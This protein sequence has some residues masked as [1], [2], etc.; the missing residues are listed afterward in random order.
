VNRRP[1]GP[2]TVVS[3][4]STNVVLIASGIGTWLAVSG[5]LSVA[6]N[7]V[8]MAAG[9]GTVPDSWG[10]M[11]P[12]TVFGDRGGIE[13][14]FGLDTTTVLVV[15]ALLFV[16]LIPGPAIWAISAWMRRPSASDG[17]PVMTEGNIAADLTLGATRRRAAALRPTLNADP[18]GK[19]IAAPDAGLFLGTLDR[20]KG[21]SVYSSWEDTVLALFAPR[22]GKTTA[23]AIPFVLHAPGAVVATSNKSDL[24]AATQSLR[25]SG[26]DA[27][28]TVWTFDPQQI[29][30]TEQ[31]WWWDP[32][33]DIFTIEDAE[34]FAGHFIGT[35]EDDK[36]KDIWGPAATELLANLILAAA[37][38]DKPISTVYEW[39]SRE[40]DRAAPEILADHGFHRAS[41]ALDGLQQAAPETRASVY[42]TARSGSKCLRNPEITQWVEPGQARRVFD[43][44]AFAKSTDTL[45]LLS[46]D[47]GASAAPLVAAITDRVMRAAMREAEG[48]P[49]GRLD[50]PMVIVLDE[51]ANIC[52]LTELA[53]LVSHAGSRGVLPVTVLQNFPQGQRVWGELGM[54]ALWAAST[55]KIIGSGGD[56][57]DLA[58]KVSKLIGDHDVATVSVTSSPQHGSAQTSIQQRRVMALAEVNAMPKGRAIVMATGMKPIVVKLQPS[59]TSPDAA[60][61]AAA[62]KTTYERIAAAAKA[63]AP[64]S[65]TRNDAP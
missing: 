10:L 22:S 43:A 36:K 42:F 25:E 21:P 57:D 31:T 60:R 34:R 13:A 63:T 28:D 8:S 27:T 14:A 32:L 65:R 46:K 52:P 59:Y 55:V 41:G 20:K 54:K 37:L 2:A 45:Y 11:L 38:D 15:W 5:L 58:E 9:K 19:N 40:A 18:S 48:R 6:I 23:L 61:I 47:G 49:R 56:D 64:V 29:A 39:L 35:V 44:A 3:S 1:V 51:A 33:A 17:I 7:A 4:D 24:V 26:R 30:Y 16:V 53:S 62:E 50:P 12:V